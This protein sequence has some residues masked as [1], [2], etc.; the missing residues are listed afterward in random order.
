MIFSDQ[1]IILWSDFF[2][3]AEMGL[4][5]WFFKK[6]RKSTL[7]RD[8]LSQGAIDFLD[9]KK[10]TLTSEDIDP[11]GF[12]LF[13]G[14]EKAMELKKQGKLNEAA[15]ILIKSTNPAS[16]YHGHYR[17]LFRIWRQFNREDLKLLKYKDVSERVKLMCHLDGE[18][19]KEMLRYWGERQGRK[20][21]DDYFTKDRNILVS[22]A[23]AL[24]KSAEAL[25]NNDDIYLADKLL[26]QLKS[27]SGR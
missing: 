18:M 6:E 13:K 19:N 14:Y 4:F 12:A 3:G 7:S 16:I 11:V 15:D 23:K 8:G 26:S 20:L 24:K 21:P 22:D 9:G 27:S 25:E 2:G 10:S 5:S 1:K 17:E